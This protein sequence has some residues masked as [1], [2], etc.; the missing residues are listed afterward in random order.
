[1]SLVST[2]VASLQSTLG[3]S[4]A[5]FGIVN[6]QNQMLDNIRKAG[7]PNLGF[8]GL[9]ALHDRENNLMAQKLRQETMY[10]IYSAK[11]ESDD[12]MLKD[13]IKRNF[14]IFA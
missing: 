9:K 10:Q 4:N 13:S 2:F 6:T 3:L 14:S 7:N 11:A 5:T 8:G 1:M 12:K